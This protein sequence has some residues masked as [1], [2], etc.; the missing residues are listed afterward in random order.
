MKKILV[1]TDFSEQA[2]NALDFAIQIAR[3][4]EAAIILLNVLD[5]P[6]LSTV[7]M[8]GLNIIGGTEPP[9]DHLDE[10]FVNSLLDKAKD[11]L[12]DSIRTAGGTGMNITPKV[13]IGNPYFCISEKITAEDINLVVMGTRGISGLEDVLIGSTAEKVVRLS[14]CPVITIKQKCELN[15]I[16]HMIFASNF[17]EKQDHI[18]EELLKMQQILDATLH[19]VKVNTPNNFQSNQVMTREM[20]EFVEKYGI[21]K[22]TTNLYNDY[23]EED[24]I[25][26]FAEDI[27]ADM[28]S[29]ATHGRTGL[30]HLLSGSIAEDVVNHARRPVWTCRIKN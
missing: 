16:K 28:I 3:R 24:G 2:K 27:D 1:P 12:A 26:H 21:R 30:M 19:L 23:L 13:E 18:V 11:E 20:K 14:Q 29:L 22:Y 8:G 7:W 25:I 10:T 4:S 15:K 6:G 9:A 17:E 5:Y